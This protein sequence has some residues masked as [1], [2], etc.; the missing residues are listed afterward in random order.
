MKTFRIALALMLVLV[1]AA[2][3]VASA[4]TGLTTNYTTSITYQNVST[5]NAV[6]TFQFYNEKTASA[7]T[8]NR[9]INAGAG[10]S[11]FLGSLSGAEALPEGF[12]GSVVMGSNQTIVGT[13]VQVPQNS[14]VKNR[15]LSN[16]FSG[17][18]SQV[19]LATILKNVFSTSSTFSIQNA[20]TGNINI[21]VKFF[22]VGETAPALTLTENDIPSGS[23]KF[24]KAGLGAS[25]NGS[26]VV[27]AVKSTGGLPA[28]IVG[29]VLELGTTNL[30]AKAFEGIGSGSANLYV[31]TALCN[32]FGGT[33]TAYAI[34]NTDNA[35]AASVTV[36]Y[37]DLAG[38]TV[39]TDTKNI[40]AGGKQSFLA[41]DKAPAGFSGSAQVQSSGPAIVAVAKA[42]KPDPNYGTAFLGASAGSVKIALP[43]VRYTSQANY[44]SG[45]RQ[46]TF[47]AIQN[48]GGATVN[49]VVVKYL[50]KDGTVLG[51]HTI[52]S[53]ASGSKANTNAT[54]AT[55]NAAKLA[56]F[57]NPE[58]NVGG[59]FGGAVIIEGPAGSSLIAVGRV[60]SRA[61]GVDVAEDYNGIAIQ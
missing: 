20:D 15:P 31:A 50:D 47:I 7:V 48:I 56:E 46:R 36:T 11:L 21:T 27:T 3:G 13:M 16:G 43:Y 54:L 25:F 28:N 4:Q 24:Y 53:I 1:V 57:G 45:A 61:N 29:S 32:V 17:G 52:P 23:A 12:L 51:T 19:L 41:C 8:I 14:P 6:V 55:G 30:A 39:G 10:S 44:D 22:R 35:N 34:Q 59:G 33:S 18:G 37:K 9:S 42:T 58:A 60:Q 2:F 40:S 49:N 5:Q 38:A 26:A